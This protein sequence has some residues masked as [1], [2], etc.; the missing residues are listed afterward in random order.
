MN[1]GAADSWRDPAALG[2]PKA[3]GFRSSASPPPPPAK[4]IGGAPARLVPLH[5][6][7]AWFS[8]RAKVDTF[9]MGKG[10]EHRGGSWGRQNV[11]GD[12]PYNVTY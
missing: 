1:L 7:A 6:G 10:D 3:Y 5:A 4:E 8:R 2:D 9:F 12:T 11:I